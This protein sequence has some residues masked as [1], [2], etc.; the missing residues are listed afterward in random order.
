MNNRHRQNP[1][2][3]SVLTATNSRSYLQTLRALMP[4]RALSFREALQRAELQAARLLELSAVA[5]GPVP[6][7]VITSQPRITV[8]ESFRA[9]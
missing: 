1:S 6:E 8:E 3:E 4:A 5:D 9:W 2:L 7:S